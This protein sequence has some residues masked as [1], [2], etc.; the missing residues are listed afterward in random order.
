MFGISFPELLV[1]AVVCLVVFGPDKLP[2]LARNLGR[3]SAQL[4]RASDSIRRDF[5][6]ELYPPLPE[7]PLAQAKRELEAVSSDVKATFTGAEYRERWDTCESRNKLPPQPEAAAPNDTAVPT[8]ATDT[9]E[10]VVKE[11]GGN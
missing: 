11:P 10:A 8:L 7:N 6:R 9:K 3:I 1:I 4:R 5:Y 2:E